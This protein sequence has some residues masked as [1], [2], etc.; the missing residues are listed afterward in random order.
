[1]RLIVLGIEYGHF[2][3]TELTKRLLRAMKDYIRCFAIARNIYS[4]RR[5]A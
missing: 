4:R 1:M 5:V 3:K 2:M